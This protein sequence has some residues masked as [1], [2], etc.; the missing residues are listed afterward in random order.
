MKWPAPFPATV[1][2][3][4]EEG[5]TIGTHTE[6]HPTRF[7]QLPLEKMRRLET[8]GKGILLLHDIHPATVAALPGLL[9]ELKDKGFHIVQVVPSASYVIAMANKPKAQSLASTLPG[10][11]MIADDRNRG[12]QPRWPHDIL[13]EDFMSDDWDA[14]R[15]AFAWLRESTDQKNTKRDRVICG[16]RWYTPQTIGSMRERVRS[17]Q[18]EGTATAGANNK[19]DALGLNACACDANQGSAVSNVHGFCNARGALRCSPAPR[20]ASAAYP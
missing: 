10:E 9:K 1:R 12:A 3:I 20:R 17:Q 16:G 2:R 6:H 4:Y 5:H 11:P 7:G 19:D 15:E 14:Y 13:V 18:L 8:R